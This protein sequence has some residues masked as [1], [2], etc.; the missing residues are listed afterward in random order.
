[1]KRVQGRSGT[2][3]ERAEVLWQSWGNSEPSMALLIG[4]RELG[5]LSNSGMVKEERV[6]KVHYEI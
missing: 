3:H 4:E 2:L 1:M 5:L 6:V